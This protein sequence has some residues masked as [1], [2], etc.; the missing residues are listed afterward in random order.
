MTLAIGQPTHG[1][2][3]RVLPVLGLVREVAGRHEQ[4]EE[5]VPVAPEG[6]V[7]AARADHRVQGGLDAEVVRE[8]G[9]WKKN[10]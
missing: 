1:G 4:R 9:R 2:V 8:V 3:L 5:E 6:G 7:V 10:K